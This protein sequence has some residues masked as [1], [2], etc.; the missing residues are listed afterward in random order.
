MQSLANISATNALLQ[1]YGLKAKY[2][3]GQNFLV[4]QQ[5]LDKIINLSRVMPGYNVVEV[6][7]GIGTLT[8]ALVD[9]G[10][11]VTA[12]E[13][14]ED[15]IP[16]IKETLPNVNLIQGDALKTVP[17]GN[18]LISNL[19]YNVAAPILITY[20]QQNP[21]LKSA[22]V[23]VQKE[24]AD[25]IMAKPKSKN[26]GAFTVKLGFYAE[27]VGSFGVSSS[28]FLPAPR[29]DST[30]IR[31]DRVGHE[32]IEACNL[33][34]AVFAHRRK[35]IANNLKLANNPRFDEAF[36]DVDLSF[37]AEV[38]SKKDFKRIVSQLPPKDPANK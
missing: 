11:N 21:N 25:R 22:T 12:V 7:P 15:L 23:M 10:A 38:L 33:V 27:V 35:T 28:C 24:I 5:I 32:S 37:R 31:L 36:A 17:E 4:N 13:M 19:P 18:M 14:D 8:R 34:D 6:G 9:E 20:F 1:E 29:V 2:S 16:V 26:Y 30:V 3:Y